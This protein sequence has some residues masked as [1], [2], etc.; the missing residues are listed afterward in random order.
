MKTI[1]QEV[2]IYTQLME[3][4]ER[5]G[6][7]AEAENRT[8]EENSTISQA[9]VD[10]IKAEGI[11]H[12]IKPKE[13]GHPQISFN[14]YTDMIRK[15]GYYNLS[16]AWL[17]YFYSLH[18]SWVAY[19]PKHR[20]DEVYGTGG[21][22]ADIF[23]PIGKAEKVEGGFMLS[24]HWKFVSGINYSEWVGVGAFYF[25][26]EGEPPEHIAFC[27]HKKDFKLIKEWDSLG[28]RGSGSNT[29]IIEDLFV[30]DDM[31]LNFNEIV[32]RRRPQPLEVDEDYLYYNVSFFPAF[33]V[34]FP[35]MA[36]GAAERIIDEYRERTKKRV[37]I[38]GQTASE[39]P[40]AQRVLAEMTLKYQAASGMMREYVDMLNSDEG[41]Y[42]PALYN[43]IR[44]QIIQNCMDIAVRATLAFGAGSLAKG[45]PL[46]VM[47]RDLTAIAT[48]ITSL[49]ED[50]LEHYGKHLFGFDTFSKG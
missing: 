11:H 49:Y 46:E 31:V 10:L 41:Q 18:N 25:K 2:D 32:Q 7:L 9:V 48:H 37:R 47:L 23:P 15:V 28:L 6:K 16:A 3:S 29:I 45:N 50:G 20:M 4:A 14:T 34:G 5:I 1:I 44:V 30:P 22:I 39:S 38:G 8:A 26:N 24:G 27:V 13:Y 36:L 43:G 19:L 40:T 12:L 42:N 35:A 21:L 33:F 17:T